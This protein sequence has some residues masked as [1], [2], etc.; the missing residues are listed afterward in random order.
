MWRPP[1]P[2][3]KGI[4]EC[5]QLQAWLKSRSHCYFIYINS[6]RKQNGVGDGPWPD[7]TPS[8]LLKQYS[9]LVIK[10]L[11]NENFLDSFPVSTLVRSISTIEAIRSLTTIWIKF[12]FGMI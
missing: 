10:P 3:E 12:N 5:Q 8:R 7:D 6:L 1:Q 4:M 2:L 11:L 9:S